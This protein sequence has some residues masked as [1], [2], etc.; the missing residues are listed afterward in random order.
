MGPGWLREEFDALDVDFDGR[1][2]LRDEQIAV[3]RA[4]WR[5]AVV[6][7]AGPRMR[8]GPVVVEPKPASTIP[9][10]VGGH[11]RAAVRRA[12]RLGDG[13]FP[14]AA[15]GDDLVTLVEALHRLTAE[16][17]RAVSDIEI[18]ADAPRTV[19]QAATVIELGVARVL[20][21]APAVPT[22]RLGDALAERRDAVEALLARV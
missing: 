1:G 14:L 18:T 4:A 13:F 3:L 17:G 10:V 7:H 19:E 11:T 21:N 8:F 15:R 22:E 16:A 5:D 12:A 20:L 6:E 2:A 9:I